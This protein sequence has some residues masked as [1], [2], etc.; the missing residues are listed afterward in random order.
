MKYI[1]KY[2]IENYIQYI[3]KFRLKYNSSV[4]LLATFFLFCWLIALIVFELGDKT[5]FLWSLQKFFVKIFHKSIPKQICLLC[6]SII[7]F[8]PDLHS[9]IVSERLARLYCN[10]SNPVDVFSTT[11]GLAQEIEY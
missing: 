10:E 3:N 8:S 6:I 5:F 11:F 4:L 7:K 1:W 2:L 9:I